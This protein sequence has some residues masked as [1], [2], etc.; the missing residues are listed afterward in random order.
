LKQDQTI[1]CKKCGFANPLHVS[2]CLYC[3]DVLIPS[4]ST[5]KSNKVIII[6]GILLLLLV[7]IVAYLLIF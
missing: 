5:K 6:V 3:G 7:A 4:P 1:K 2:N